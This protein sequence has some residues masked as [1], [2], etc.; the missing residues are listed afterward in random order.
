MH[1]TI[2]TTSI[3]PVGGLNHETYVGTQYCIHTSRHY[4]LK[5]I[6]TYV[7]RYISTYLELIR[8]IHAN[9]VKLA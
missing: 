9:T 3:V 5:N 2:E 7:D 8:I 4:E 1:L 6:H